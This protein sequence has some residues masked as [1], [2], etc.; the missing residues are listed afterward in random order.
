MV[1][2]GAALQLAFSCARDSNQIGFEVITAIFAGNAERTMINFGAGLAKAA[3]MVKMGTGLPALAGVIVAVTVGTYIIAPELLNSVEETGP[4]PAQV[5][6]LID[7]SAN[8]ATPPSEMAPS[9]TAS[10]A[11]P[12]AIAV[13]DLV[14]PSFDLLRV[15]PDGSTVIAGKAQPGTRLDIMSGETV[16]AS[17]AVGESGDFATVLDT[18][19]AAGDHSLTLRNT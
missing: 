5:S 1:K 15:E 18:P 2:P 4:Q 8:N 11:A 9:E 19:L 17:I 6:G 7:G 12:E 13:D 16:I 14:T 10:L 3:G